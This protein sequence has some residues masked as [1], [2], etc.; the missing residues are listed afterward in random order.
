MFDL[1]LY[2]EVEKFY[3]KIIK[4]NP[5]NI[6]AAVR[7]ANVLE[8][9]GENESALALIDSFRDLGKFNLKRDLMKIKLSL[10]NSTPIELSQQIDSLILN[11]ENEK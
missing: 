2:S 11:M 6:E 8:E 9:K 5:S 7:L 4:I 3:R 1:G 10:L